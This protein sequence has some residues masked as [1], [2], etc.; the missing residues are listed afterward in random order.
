MKPGIIDVW[1]ISEA[2]PS[3]P[4]EMNFEGFSVV[5]FP[6]VNREVPGFVYVL[7]WVGESEEVPFYVGQTSRIWGRLDD[8]YWAMFTACTDFRVGEAVRYL[9]TKGYRVVVKYK[10]S[11][12]PRSEESD[13]IRD[14]HGLR[15]ILLNDLSGYPYQKADETEER[16]RVQKFLRSNPARASFRVALTLTL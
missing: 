8:Y 2:C 5:D 9:S 10:S 4:T 3:Q 11:V 16:L 6:P 1:T 14:L 7:C 15:R 13:I 12:D